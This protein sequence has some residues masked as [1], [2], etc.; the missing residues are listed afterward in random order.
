MDPGITW[1]DI[2]HTDFLLHKY[3]Q[4]SLVKDI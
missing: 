1:K 2:S 3:M 4:I